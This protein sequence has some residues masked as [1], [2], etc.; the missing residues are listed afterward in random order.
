MRI[1][2]LRVRKYVIDRV[3]SHRIQPEMLHNAMA[4]HTNLS[5]WSRGFSER[6]QLNDRVW[7][8][9]DLLTR[10]YSIIYSNHFQASDQE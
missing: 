2:G 5:P 7:A 8:E 10:D 6:G 1:L 4:S 9:G 3:I